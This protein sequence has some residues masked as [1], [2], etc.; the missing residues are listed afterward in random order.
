MYMSIPAIVSYDRGNTRYK[1]VRVPIGSYPFK[2]SRPP[3][4]EGWLSWL[5]AK[6]D[7]WV[8]SSH[9]LASHP[10][11]TKQGCFGSRYCSK[12]IMDS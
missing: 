8:F 11:P 3:P 9:F 6:Q 1:N 4:S 5:S 7:L 10:S 2:D 12:L